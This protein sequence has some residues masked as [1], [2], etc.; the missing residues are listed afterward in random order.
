MISVQNKAVEYQ[1]LLRDFF[2]KLLFKDRH[3]KSKEIDEFDFRWGFLNKSRYPNIGLNQPNKPNSDQDS[4]LKMITGVIF[5]PKDEIGRA[6]EIV[7]GLKNLKRLA[8]TTIDGV[9]LA[10]CPVCKDFQQFEDSASA[11]KHLKNP[12]HMKN[13]RDLR[14]RLEGPRNDRFDFNRSRDSGGSRDGSFNVSGTSFG[15]GNISRGSTR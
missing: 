11:K 3:I 6:E 9:F 14:E 13:V 8:N 5:P 1:N 12:V 15:S 4:S 2:D 7:E 10:E